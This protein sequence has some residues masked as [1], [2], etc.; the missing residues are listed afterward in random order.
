MDSP[1]PMVKIG[2]SNNPRARYDQIRTA[3]PFDVR[4]IAI[5]D[6][7]ESELHNRFSDKRITKEWF[8]YD[9]EMQEFVKNFLIEVP[10]NNHKPMKQKII[11]EVIIKPAKNKIKEKKQNNLWGFGN[12]NPYHYTISFIDYWLLKRFD[13]VQNNKI[14]GWQFYG[15]I[16]RQN[17]GWRKLTSPFIQRALDYFGWEL[18]GNV[19]QAKRL[20]IFALSRIP[21]ELESRLKGRDYRYAGVNYYID[22]M[23]EIAETALKNEFRKP[24]TE[25]NAVANALEGVTIAGTPR[26]E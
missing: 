15:W 12:I 25:A 23:K 16:C 3:N 17:Y 22:G 9:N 7:S 14:Y 8:R 1:E 21:I 26:T 24:V 5:T 19:E 20:R 18:L 2:K 4:L 10:T 6:I 11:K 13:E